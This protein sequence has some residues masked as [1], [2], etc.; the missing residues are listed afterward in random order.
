MMDFGKSK[1][2]TL[3]WNNFYKLKQIK[4]YRF[5]ILTIQHTPGFKVKF[6]LESTM[7]RFFASL[8]SS[9]SESENEL[10]ESNKKNKFMN[11]EFLDSDSQSDFSDYS[12][13]G[14]DASDSE[15]DDH[16]E[17]QAAPVRKSRF[18]MVSDSEDDEDASGRVLKS[19]KEKTF[20]E[21]NATIS[22]INDSMSNEDWNGANI[23][24]DRL[25]KV[26]TKN[27]R[28]GLPSE[29]FVFLNDI[30]NV[31]LAKLT[32]AEV[33]KLE[34]DAAKAFN[35]LR[36]KTRKAVSSYATEIKR[37]TATE[38][39]INQASAEMIKLPKFGKIDDMIRGE[40]NKVIELTPEN[41]TRKLQEIIASRGKKNIDRNENLN[42]LRK[43]LSMAASSEQKIQILNAQI[44]TEF[45]IASLGSSSYMP[46]SLWNSALQNIKLML[47]LLLSDSKFYAQ[48]EDNGSKSGVD[49]DDMDGFVGLPT[50]AGIRGSFSSY[51]YRIDDEYLRALQNID[52]HSNEYIDF[53]KEELILASVLMKS[54]EFFVAIGSD[55]AECNVVARFF[56]HIYYKD[57]AS[58]SKCD[59][60][61]PS[62]KQI[63]E[64]ISEK[65]NEKL[66]QKV[67]LCLVYNLS[68]NNDYKSAREIFL[69]G[70]FQ[71]IASSLDVQSQIIYNRA[72]VQMAICAFRL[73]LIKDCYFSL[74]EICSSGRPKE[75]L[76]QGSQGQR[77]T[78]KTAEQDRIDR[79]RQLPTHMHLNIELIDCIFLTCS[80]IL[81]VPQSALFSK[82]IN[83]ND[84]K[85]YQSRHLKRLMDAM[86]RSVFD[87]P[88][89]NTRESLV[90]AAR[91]LALAD[92][93]SASRLCTSAKAWESLPCF[94]QGTR[95]MVINRIKESALCTFIFSYGSSFE[96]VSLEYLSETF[97]LPIASVV[98]LVNNLIPETGITAS[99][100]QDRKFLVWKN[101]VE[102]TRIQ[103]VALVLSDKV[104]VIIDRNEETSE[105]IRR[106]HS[107]KV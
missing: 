37:A 14:S 29:F 86:E 56:E 62:G 5:G 103:E 20:D 67:Q 97:E 63:Y 66:K 58:L 98:E 42:T 72:L 53:M 4:K 49:G 76:A 52:S 21:I 19:Q 68:L 6:L 43:L 2:L 12:S 99:F 55:E 79:Q 75:L 51:L 71:E 33:K 54:R 94:N 80:M 83:Q 82:K 39:E 95:D 34:K 77:F 10:F 40:S 100:D 35:A 78:E 59:P 90:M 64:M 9:G 106:P 74:Q 36:Q 15:G 105:M 73:G 85:M 50:V 18:L 65:A 28:L 69:A 22:L 60:V 48:S 27:S 41:V 46:Y 44:S 70:R 84:R 104:Q 3:N 102:L 25:M 107:Y 96:S 91:S 30:E 89:E 93:E 87:G 13:S 88:A 8:E 101:S 26:V 7:S 47:E 16:E 92:W 24:F 38:E 32:A 61:F 11:T 1:R 81:E 17:E 45:D 23:N 57:N 31:H